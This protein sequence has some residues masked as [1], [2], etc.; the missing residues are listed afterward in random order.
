MVIACDAPACSTATRAGGEGPMAA[1]P[2]RS[3]GRLRGTAQAGL[4]AAL[5]WVLLLAPAAHA[6][7]AP[8]LDGDGVADALDDCPANPNPHQED[9]DGDGTGDPCDPDTVNA[10]IER[11]AAPGTDLHVRT[12]SYRLSVTSQPAI[13]IGAEGGLSAVPNGGIGIPG[14]NDTGVISLAPTALVGPTG[15][16]LPPRTPTL[17][18]STW[19]SLRMSALFAPPGGGPV[20]AH[21]GSYANGVAIGYE[22]PLAAIPTGAGA[23]VEHQ[24]VLPTGWTLDA[25]EVS[26]GGGIG[27]ITLSDA[28]GTPRLRISPVE[29]GAFGN[30]TVIEASP[31]FFGLARLSQELQASAATASVGPPDLVGSNV[32]GGIHAPLVETSYTMAEN[33]ADGAAGTTLVLALGG[34][35][36]RVTTAAP[37]AVID[38]NRA[39]SSA[40]LIGFRIASLA[41]VDLDAVARVNGRHLVLFDDEADPAGVDVQFRLHNAIGTFDGLAP[42]YDLFPNGGGT[43]ALHDAADQQQTALG[44]AGSTV[45]LTGDAAIEFAGG[46]VGVGVG[47][48]GRVAP[49]NPCLL[50]DPIDPVTATGRCGAGL[51]LRGSFRADRLTILGSM[52]GL[53]AGESDVEIDEL[54]FIQAH[55]PNATDPTLLQGVA[56]L[57]CA[58]DTGVRIGVNPANG[59]VLGSVPFDLS[60]CPP[61]DVGMGTCFPPALSAPAVSGICN[62]VVKR[63]ELVGMGSRD[64]PL[65]TDLTLPSG[66]GVALHKRSGKGQLGGLAFDP[67]ADACVGGFVAAP[68]V[69]KGFEVMASFSGG[70]NVDPASGQP[71]RF[72]ARSAVLPSPSCLDNAFGSELGAGLVVG[73][74][75]DVRGSHLH[76][77]DTLMG[78]IAIGN[79]AANV[80]TLAST[81]AAGAACRSLDGTTCATPMQELACPDCKQG[82]LHALAV[83]S[84]GKSAKAKLA[85]TASA[86]GLDEDDEPSSGGNPALPALVLD[87]HLVATGGGLTIARRRA[88]L[89]QTPVQVFF[90]PDTMFEPELLE[91]SL[92]GNNI[93]VRAAALSIDNF[94]SAGGTKSLVLEDNCYTPGGGVCITAAD[95]EPVLAAAARDD[96]VVDAND[97]AKAAASPVLN[98]VPEPAAALSLAS[99]AALVA[100]LHARRRRRARAVGGA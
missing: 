44:F 50:T 54:V 69:I 65:G 30:E 57:V 96:G 19:Q 61:E 35:A 13:R 14:S 38:R 48:G 11:V 91:L 15:G 12:P 75:A 88:G 49:P 80:E 72:D 73:P 40:M 2:I 100:A 24:L 63:V 74:N 51:L 52:S 5:A 33:M 45:E 93:G 34:S 29:V 84:S 71:L 7:P 83:S 70:A 10:V 77:A 55:D 25:S 58:A 64:N 17:E 97:A 47:P 26:A 41:P 42:D 36:F 92:V 82:G 8:D 67:L 53:V 21:V 85:V 60:A 99:G 20:H 23:A 98:L 16:P 43:A 39:T 76:I 59:D 3:G 37:A 31:T 95:P 56:G 1:T 46:G 32:S 27:R 87:E 90:G 86:L 4:A 68:S 79:G 78:A 66:V 28:G 94:D 9:S 89:F 22:L 62:L 81:S 6:Q 18:Q